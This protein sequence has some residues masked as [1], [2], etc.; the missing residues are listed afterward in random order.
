MTLRHE[1]GTIFLDGVCPVEDAEPLLQLL[2]SNPGAGLDWTGVGPMHTAILQIIL[3][4][5][6]APAGTCGDA[7]LAKWATEIPLAFGDTGGK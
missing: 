2:L 5:G 6:I 3:A 1:H 4:A 7:W